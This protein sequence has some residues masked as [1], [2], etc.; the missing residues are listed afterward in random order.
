MMAL[1]PFIL[2]LPTEARDYLIMTSRH[3]S[4]EPVSQKTAQKTLA[5]ARRLFKAADVNEDGMLEENELANVVQELYM[6]LDTKMTADLRIRVVEEA[7]R[8]INQLYSLALCMS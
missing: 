5:L 2:M 3:R 4:T 8:C 6:R 1:K 7:R